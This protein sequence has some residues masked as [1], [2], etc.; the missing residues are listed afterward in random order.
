MPNRRSRPYRYIPNTN[1]HNP[2]ERFT[3]P[4]GKL[5]Y[6]RSPMKAVR[7][8]NLLI[9]FRT[10]NPD[11]ARRLISVTHP[12]VVL[13]AHRKDWVKEFINPAHD[14][15]EIEFGRGEDGVP[16]IVF[17]VLDEAH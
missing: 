5:Y 6:A 14:Y 9:V 13:G 10:H 3:R 12:D 15:H 17:E 1:P 4:N 16:A 8:L 2:T 11:T 7:Y